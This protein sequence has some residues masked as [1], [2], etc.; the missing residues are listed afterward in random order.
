LL[1]QLLDEAAALAQLLAQMLQLRILEAF[2]QLKLLL[3][4]T[5]TLPAVA[6]ALAARRRRVRGVVG[7]FVHAVELEAKGGE[8]GRRRVFVGST[9]LAREVGLALGHARERS[10][11]RACEV[12]GSLSRA[13]DVVA[14]HGRSL[15][16]PLPVLPPLEHHLPAF[17]AARLDE[18]EPVSLVVDKRAHKLLPRLRRHLEPAAAPLPVRKLAL[19]GARRRLEDADPVLIAA[20]KLA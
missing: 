6:A 19:V 2:G 11:G 18:G 17:L 14:R 8:R 16:R 20:A 15:A 1:A 7:V 12:R 4:E 3:R 13:A 5:G 10:K 9:A